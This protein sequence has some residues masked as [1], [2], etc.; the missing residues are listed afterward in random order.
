MIVGTVLG[1]AGCPAGGQTGDNGTATGEPEVIAKDNGPKSAT[2]MCVC[3]CAGDFLPMENTTD[4]MKCR[5]FQNQACINR[6]GDKEGVT[7]DC[8]IRWV[9]PAKPDV[10]GVEV[11]DPDPPA[12]SPGDSDSGQ[13]SAPDQPGAQPGPQ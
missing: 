3:K 10:D 7:E 6:K 1:L 4:V 8:K 9:Y 11:V 5:T 12:T 13:P 2:Q